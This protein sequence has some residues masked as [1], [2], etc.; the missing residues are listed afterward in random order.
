MIDN[1]IWPK[2]DFFDFQL[3]KSK[4]WKVECVIVLLF[5]SAILFIATF[6]CSGEYFTLLLMF[7]CRK[8]T[9]FDAQQTILWLYN[10]QLSIT[11]T[12]F[13]FWESAAKR[14]NFW[15]FWIKSWIN[16]TVLRVFWRSI[17]YYELIYVV[18]SL[19][20]CFGRSTVIFLSRHWIHNSWCS[21]V[22]NNQLFNV[23]LFTIECYFDIVFILLISTK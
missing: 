19:M 13:V 12:F 16:I 4:Y 14:D 7:N 23:L 20:F 8:A 21:T 5:L 15:E 9:G 6:I 22:F 18:F 1:V 2:R 11:R 17:I 3:S 10:I